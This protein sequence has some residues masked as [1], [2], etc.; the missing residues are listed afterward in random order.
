VLV[1]QKDREITASWGAGTEGEKD[2]KEN[3]P[4]AVPAISSN[5]AAAVLE[6]VIVKGDLSKLTEAERVKYYRTV[7]ESIG[8]N[9]LTRP[10]DYIYLNGR[11][12][13]YATRNCTD[14]LR[15]N[16]N[17]SVQIVAR[18]QKGDI[19]IV[20]ARATTPDGRTDESIGAVCLAGLGGDA[21]ANAYMKAETKAKRR[22]TLSIV[23]LSLLDETEIETVSNAKMAVPERSD[24]G[25][26][27]GAPELPSIVEAYTQD[28]AEA[29]TIE[30]LRNIGTRIRNDLTVEKSDREKLAELYKQRKEQLSARNL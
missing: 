8:V 18:E 22:V 9:P 17:I 12:T 16:R 29:T 15:N 21:L 13:L 11:L 27:G 20:T 19:Y 5:D 23:G 26:N 2:M 10:L 24:V 6:Q 1:V 7:C 4:K 30:Q 25:P 3:E 28:I 14:Q